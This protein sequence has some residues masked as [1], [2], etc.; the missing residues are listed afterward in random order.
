MS[1]RYPGFQARSR[2]RPPRGMNDTDELMYAYESTIHN[3][4]HTLEEY[5]YYL[6]I[7]VYYAYTCTMHSMHT[8]DIMDTTT[9]A[10][11]IV[12]IKGLSKNHLPEGSLRETRPTFKHGLSRR[13]PPRPRKK[14]WCMPPISFICRGGIWRRRWLHRL[15]SR[16]A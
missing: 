11:S 12:L 5:P 4:I 2:S 3:I 1:I 8:M 9:P 10:S 6:C 15:R 13:N 14:L 16:T 7:H